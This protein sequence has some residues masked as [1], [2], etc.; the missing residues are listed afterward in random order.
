MDGGELIELEF[1]PELRFFLAR[2]FR[3]GLATAPCDGTSSLGHVV[4]SLG[5]PLTEV[6]D[7]SI[8]GRPAG[9]ADRLAPG[10]RVE[11][12]P[13]HRPQP[14]R[15]P[16]F[17]LDVHLGALARRMRL[18]G[19][20]TAYRNDADDTE[21][22]DQANA[23]RRVALTKDRGLLRR[24][25]LWFGA[26][27]R[28]DRPDDQLAD[29]LDRFA[30]PLRPWTR[31]PACNGPLEAI[32]KHRVEHLLPSGTRRTYQDFSRCSGCGRLYWRGAH[33]DR[34]DAL[35]ARA[36]RSATP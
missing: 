3:S 32:A 31:C 18:V 6:G 33:S 4:E 24:R 15:A 20:D 26:Y 27:V 1:A 19:L 22:V 30:P 10:D 12:R 25:K 17:V 16:R 7:L 9:P 29:V 35:V 28:H 21:L 23:E 11:I 13:V 8:G 14:L 36:A 5:V 2:R 34:L